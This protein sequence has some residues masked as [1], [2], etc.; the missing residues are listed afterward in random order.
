MFGGFVVYAFVLSV[1]LTLL[2]GKL[3]F[4]FRVVGRDVNK[5]GKIILPEQV[6]I[7]FVISFSVFFIILTYAFGKVE[8]L[9]LLL[10]A[11][12]VSVFGFVDYFRSFSPKTKLMFPFL[13][14]LLLAFAIYP[15]TGFSKLII[16]IVIAIGFAISSNL[17]N[18]LGGFNGLEIGM[19]TLAACGL[20]IFFDLQNYLFG[21]YAMM[22]LAASLLGFLVFNIYPAKVFPGDSGTLFCGAIISGIVLLSPYP[23]VLPIA[24]APHIIDATLKFK[25]AGLMSR[26]E[27]KPVALKGKKLHLPKKTYSSLSRHFLK[28]PL[29]EVQLVLRVLGTEIIIILF[30]A[31]LGW[32]I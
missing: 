6:G 28:T 18:M 32:L 23:Y 14:G 30:L 1:V 17:T 12:L 20:G 27:F 10:A 16:G 29:T 4:K 3:M 9:W 24:L 13:A 11:I 26:S 31:L 5:K 25:S 21:S 15:W 8:L 7:S 22:L 19:S 2:I